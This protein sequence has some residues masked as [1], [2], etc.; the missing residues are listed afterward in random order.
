MRPFV[1]V[2]AIASIL[3][4]PAG[5]QVTLR[6]VTRLVQIT[7]VAQ[8]GE[9]R[10]VTNLARE[11]F[12]LFDAGES[13]EIKVF[14]VDRADR[15]NV[16]PAAEP[17]NPVER[18]FTNAEPERAGPTGVTVILL[19][20]LNTKWNDQSRACRDV[21]RF[22]SQ[23]HPD[24]RI[25][26]YSMGF[27]GF[28]VLHD[29]TTDASDL[30]AQ[31]ASWHG[32]IPRANS[33]DLGVQLASV[34]SGR[35]RGTTLNQ[36]SA[37]DADSRSMGQTIPTLQ[38]TELLANRLTGIPGRKNVIWISNGFPIVDWGNLASAAVSGGKPILVRSP[39]PRNHSNTVT[40][41]IGDTGQYSRQVD[42]AMH[43]LDSANVSIYPIESRG[44]QTYMPGMAGNPG[45]P[46]PRGMGSPLAAIS[47]QAT[48]QAMHDIA[49]RTGGRA[50]TLT[51]DLVGAIHSAIDDSRV[52][53]T[54]GFYPA[55][56]RQDGKFHRVTIKLAERRGVTLRYRQGYIDAPDAPSDPQQRKND[57][58]Q[59]A[60]SPLD[61][62]AI[63]L[64]ARFAPS[65]ASA[66][67]NLNLSISLAGL[68]LQ[69]E[70]EIWTG[71]VDVFLL[72]RD[73]QGQGFGRVNDT[74][75]MRLKPSTY[76]QMLKTGAPY[77]REITVSPRST[78]LRIVVRDAR[79][80]DLGSLT[81]PTR[82]LVP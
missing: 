30:L 27:T 20:S 81:I 13:R 55:S 78:L 6:S 43:L 80:G 82:G 26:I 68:N 18:V 52:T 70:G 63:P 77:R 15:V 11:D 21:I 9:G 66:A 62:N 53:Y 54:L 47:D 64:T 50:F 76:Q 23:I 59:A 12:L 33:P 32:E 60:L 73:Q 10:P 4:A 31:L 41:T 75:A 71:E 29:F 74:I 16:A 79:S 2:A 44:L 36:R 56:T 51:N 72:Q 8:D 14:T 7:V 39:D 69:P 22:L 40:D 38:V 67:Y 24:D 42:H 65:A 57:L 1:S 28:R 46:A 58:E 5:S 17:A 61:A 49:Q 34:L 19:D 25:A 48:Q 37:P 35:D 3:V 45:A